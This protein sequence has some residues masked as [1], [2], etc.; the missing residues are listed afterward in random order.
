[1]LD[2]ISSLGV[3]GCS[4]LLLA[5]FQLAY[6]ISIR[7]R[8]G[9][10]KLPGPILA[11]ISDLDRLWSCAKGLQMNY[12]LRLHD[13]YGPLVRIG[14]KHVSFSDA[15]LIPLVY[16]ISTKFWKVGRFVALSD[17]ISLTSAW[18]AISI[19][20]LTSRLRQDGSLTAP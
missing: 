1:M 8:P 5:V 11:S 16:G 7:Y 14:P 19:P 12:H 3:A 4:I 13:Q 17:T 20:C 2:L 6:L 18:R 15:T 9:L 10:R